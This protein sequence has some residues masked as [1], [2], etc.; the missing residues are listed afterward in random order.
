MER[1]LHYRGRLQ[2]FNAISVPFGIRET[3]CFREVATLHSDHLRRFHAV[4]N[5]I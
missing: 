4:Y 1:W 2:C 5:V 3:D